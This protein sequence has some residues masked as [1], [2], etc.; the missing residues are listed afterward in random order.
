MVYL[1]RCLLRT[2]HSTP[3]VILDEPTSALDVRVKR[4]ALGLIHK[5]IQ[6]K[7]MFMV[8]HNKSLLRYCD[9]E[10]RIHKGRL[11]SG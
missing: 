10:V 1:L 9:R 11:V 6:N 3:F 8:T 7:T 5:I 4:Q 2:R